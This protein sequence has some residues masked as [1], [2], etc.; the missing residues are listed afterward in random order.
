MNIL[1]FKNRADA[2]DHNS[3]PK[4]SKL[5]DVDPAAEIANGVE[6]GPF[7]VVGPNVKIGAGTRL[8]N[9]VTLMGHVTLGQDNNISPN[10]VI[11]GEPQDI[12]YKGTPTHV[13]I[14]DRN[15]I[16]ENVTINRGTE[17]EDGYT[18]IGN[19]NYLMGCA[20]VAHDCVLAD[21]I[22]IGQGS[23]LGGHVHVQSHATLS[24]CCAVHHM[25]SIGSYCFVCGSSLVLQDIPPYMLS[26]GNPARPKCVNIVA[27][28]RHNFDK[29]VI[30]NLNEAFRL[31]YRGRVG[32]DNAREVL[33]NNNSHCDDVANLLDYVAKS[34]SG[35]HGRARQPKRA[36]A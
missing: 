25:A 32:L 36:A 4:I 21:N 24:G 33:K 15:T 19:D 31:L 27:L 5:A 30:K 13:V 22:I 18:R 9:N 28:K 2:P 3:P 6:I 34:H 17:K 20:H 14:G 7:C 35:R 8:A 10:A 29:K 12:S 16:R 11:G 1:A 23:M 26:D